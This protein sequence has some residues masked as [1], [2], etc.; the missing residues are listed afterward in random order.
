MTF[1][2]TTKGTI[3]ISYWKKPNLYNQVCSK[4]I[5]KGKTLKAY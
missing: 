3:L 1:Y 4:N 2:D 5:K